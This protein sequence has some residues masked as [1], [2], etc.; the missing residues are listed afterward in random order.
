MVVH[1]EVYG[2]GTPDGLKNLSFASKLIIGSG[3]GSRGVGG[4]AA[5]AFAGLPA[6][7]PTTAPA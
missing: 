7:V 2:L 4:P 6:H 3:G 1:V 5:M